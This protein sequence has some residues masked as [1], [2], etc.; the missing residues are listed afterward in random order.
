MKITRPRTKQDIN[1]QNVFNCPTTSMVLEELNIKTSAHWTLWPAQ[2]AC[3]ARPIATD[4]RKDIKRKWVEKNDSL[5]HC[6]SNSAKQFFCKYSIIRQKIWV[7][8]TLIFSI[9]QWNL[10]TPC[11]KYDILKISPF[12][13]LRMS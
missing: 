8:P 2:C 11:A 13:S 5:I 4:N 7:R 9:W 6:Q 10:I 12:D 1:I 3:T